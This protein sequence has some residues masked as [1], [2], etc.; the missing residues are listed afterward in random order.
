MTR[1]PWM[2]ICAALLGA[3]FA[4]APLAGAQRPGGPPPGGPPPGGPRP[5]GQRPGPG[6][7]VDRLATE[8]NLTADQKTKVKAIFEAQ[9]K[10]VQA[11]MADKS[12]SQDQRMAKLRPMFEGT[13]AKIRKLLT[14]AQQKKWDDFQARM[15]QRMRERGGPGGPGGG[16]PPPGP[17]R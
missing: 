4:L 7:F 13:Q 8:L 5:G 6:Q 10:Q 15:R 3:T 1:K 16:P 11:V 2:P 9:Q 17:K 14:P 12:L